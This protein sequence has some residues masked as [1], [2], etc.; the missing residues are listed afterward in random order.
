MLFNL[1]SLKAVEPSLVK[2][3][4]TDLP[5]KISYQLSNFYD[6]LSV[7]L[8]KT[9]ELRTELVKK[10][11]EEK[12]GNVQVK[13]ENMDLFVSDYNELMSVNIEI[14]YQPIQVKTLLDHNERLEKM[15]HSPITLNGF[16]ISNLKNVGLLADKEQSNND[17][18][19]VLVS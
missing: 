16:D 18:E 5:I 4:S 12:D 13:Q 15:G 7:Q 11:G 9:E 14:A 1:G 10:Y 8:K 3:I 2:L 6:A 17:G 19:S